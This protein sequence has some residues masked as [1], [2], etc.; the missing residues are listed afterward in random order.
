MPHVSY[1][2]S[3]FLGYDVSAAL[4]AI[5]AAGFDFFELGGCGSSVSDWQFDSR[6]DAPRPPNGRAALEFRR[7]IESCGLRASTLHAPAKTNVLG[8][9]SEDWRRE[10]VML[11]ADYVRFGAEIGATGVV[12]H[13]IPNPMYL[14]DDA[15]VAAAIEPMV[16]AMQ[17]S[18]DDL[19]PVAAA[20]GAR[21][22]LE[23]LPYIHDVSVEY[24]LI[25]IRQLRPFV[26]GYPEQHVG[27]VVDTGHSWTNG[28]DPAVD[29]EMA[30]CRL[31]GTH[32]QDVPRHE[33]NDNHWLP[34]HGDLD[35]PAVCAALACVGYAGAWTFELVPGTTEA[36]P[37][38]L[39]CE[40]RE[41]A[42][43]W[44]L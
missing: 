14:P 21:I 4:D 42:R 25:T 38:E 43:G 22:L 33:P 34:T 20:A 1:S 5:A 41:V 19:L 44:G 10:K 13:G 7:L 17:R 3:G 8:P 32:L 6:A 18:L 31:W 35:W 15:D 27:L 36:S 39:A 9:P 23:N 40:A 2:A 28:D 30:G 24:P 16:A 12:M 11:L 26:D 37:E 29:I